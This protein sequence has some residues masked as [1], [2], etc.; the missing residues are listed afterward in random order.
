MTAPFSRGAPPPPDERLR[1]AALHAL[2]LLDTPNEERFDRITRTAQR[3]LDAPMA[4]VSLVDADRQWFKSC[5]GLDSR[6]TDRSVSFCAYAIHAD[7]PF[8]VPETHAD[9][10][11]AD[12][13]LVTGPP[14]IRGYLGIPIHA[15]DGYRVG[16]LCVLDDEPR[17]FSRED[18]DALVDLARW[19][20]AELGQKELAT[21]VARQ[22]AVE[23]HLRAVLDAVPE[24][25]ATFDR[26]GRILTMNPAGQRLFGQPAEELI[27]QDVGAVDRAG[28]GHRGRRQLHRCHRPAGDRADEGRVRVGGEP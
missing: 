1:L 28:E 21:A 2:N 26:S 19:A 23:E 17:Q 25:V 13:P 24:G 18:V 3:L 12:N 22:R 15:P 16:T 10:R 8:V 27:G 14:F 4:L 20:E 11:F 6:E 7:D 9:P 5:L